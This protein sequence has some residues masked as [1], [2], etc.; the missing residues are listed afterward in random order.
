MKQ[1]LREP[2]YI[3]TREPGHDWV[4]CANDVR[5]GGH[6][7]WSEGHFMETFSPVP[8]AWVMGITVGL[9]GLLRP[10]SPKSSC[11]IITPDLRTTSVAQVSRVYVAF[12]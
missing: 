5:V 1:F 4:V 2:K 8:F 3:W 10:P 7:W 11:F 9:S 6:M 12:G